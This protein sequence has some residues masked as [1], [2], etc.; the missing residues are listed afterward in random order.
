[1]TMTMIGDLTTVTIEIIT[2]KPIATIAMVT[3]DIGL[4]NMKEEIIIIDIERTKGVI[5]KM[6]TTGMQ[7]IRKIDYR[8]RDGIKGNAKQSEVKVQSRIYHQKK[9]GNMVLRAVTVIRQRMRL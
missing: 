1:M 5:G 4:T 7:M 6:V 8:I 2:M 9:I 3:I